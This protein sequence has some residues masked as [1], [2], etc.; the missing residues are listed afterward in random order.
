MHIQCEYQGERNKEKKKINGVRRYVWS[1]EGI[2]DYQ[3][4]LAEEDWGVTGVEIEK[5]WEKLKERI[6]RARKREE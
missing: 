4:K 2:Q 3:V 5:K 6:G 1:E